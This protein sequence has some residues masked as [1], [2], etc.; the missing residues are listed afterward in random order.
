MIVTAI[1]MI[2]AAIPPVPEWNCDDPQV[3]Q[4]MNWCANQEYLEADAALNA[5]WKKTAAVMKLRDENFEST[6]DDRPGYFDTLLAAQ[7]AWL[8]YRDTHCRSEGYYA[9]GGSLEPLLV[10]TCKTELTEGRTAQLA[11]LVEI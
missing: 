2:A 6:S 7:R 8:T 4:E 10:A 5:Q 9:R 11:A 1:A 3:Q